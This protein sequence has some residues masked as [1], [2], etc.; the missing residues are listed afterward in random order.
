M[1]NFMTTGSLSQGIEIDGA[2]IEGDTVPF[3][4]EDTIMMIF[5]RHPSPEM[6]R[7]LDP[8]TRTTSRSSQG[9]GDTVM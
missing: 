2:P 8:S 9:W 1:K 5:G 3:P 6:H 7:G 4:G